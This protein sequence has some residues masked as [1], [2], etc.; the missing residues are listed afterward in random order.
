[1][2]RWVRE[3]A[4]KGSRILTDRDE[5]IVL[6]GHEIVGPRQVAAVPNRYGIE[7]PAMTQVFF[8]TMEA[9]QSRDTARVADVARSYAADYFVVPWPVEGALYRDRF[10][11]LV[12]TRRNPG[13]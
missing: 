13:G 3:N 8:Q 12:A 10:F 6:Y 5:F 1:V 7:L 4:P 11:S 2:I 9:V